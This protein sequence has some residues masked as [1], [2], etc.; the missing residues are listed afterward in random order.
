MALFVHGF[1]KCVVDLAVAEYQH[2]RRCEPL[3]I[4][5]NFGFQ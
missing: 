1:S 4:G 3:L 5:V 2:D